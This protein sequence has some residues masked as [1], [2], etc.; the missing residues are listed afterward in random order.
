[1][2]YIHIRMYVRTYIS[3][4][5]ERHG[6]VLYTIFITNIYIHIL[7]HCVCRLH[8]Q[9]V[10]SPYIQCGPHLALMSPIH[11]VWTSPYPYVPHTSSVD[12]TL[13]LCPPYIQ[14]GPH[15]TPMSPIHPV[16]TSPCPYVPHTSSVDLTLPLSPPYIQCGPHL[17]PKSPIHPVWTSPCPM[18]PI[19]LVWTS[20][21]PN[22]PHT[23][24]VDLTLPHVPHTSSVDLTLP[25]CPPH[26]QCGPHLAPMSPIHPVW[27][28]PCPYVSLVVH[29]YSPPA[30]ALY[31]HS[32]AGHL[33]GV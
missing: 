3:K 26:I 23:S 30:L 10:Y 7:Y 13:P 9:I 12:L 31:G 8:Y 16:W 22:V 21:C 5:E 18:S 15:L 14:C 17:T 33:S 4:T 24:S 2:Q 25:Q 6:L 27:T 20:P 11:P 28:S 32:T 29:E 19:H 1:M